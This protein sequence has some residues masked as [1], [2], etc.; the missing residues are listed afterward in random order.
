RGQG[1]DKVLHGCHQAA[2]QIAALKRS[3]VSSSRPAPEFPGGLLLAA[4]AK[5]RQLWPA[6]KSWFPFWCPLALEKCCFPDMPACYCVIANP[7]SWVQLPPA[8]LRAEVGGRKA[9]DGGMERRTDGERQTS[10]MAIS[11]RFFFF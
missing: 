2:R 4:W 7:P 9:A 3:K 11:R 6:P 8:P 5:L 10:G 1:E